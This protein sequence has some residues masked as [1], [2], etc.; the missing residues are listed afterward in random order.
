MANSVKWIKR[1]SRDKAKVELTGPVYIALDSFDLSF[2]QDE[3]A[4]IKKL[5]K[6]NLSL[7]DIAE[8]VDREVEEVF[9]LLLDLAYKG[10]V[11]GRK[12]G[13]GG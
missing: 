11:C 8:K 10:M 12:V 3:K 4:E 13:L 7:Q 5:W 9:C 1:G 6:Q 2:Y